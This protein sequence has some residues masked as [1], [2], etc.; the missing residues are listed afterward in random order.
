MSAICGLVDS[1]SK[2]CRVDRRV[3]KGTFPPLRLE[4]FDSLLDHLA[5]F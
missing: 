4:P 2:L 5:T 3:A 1:T